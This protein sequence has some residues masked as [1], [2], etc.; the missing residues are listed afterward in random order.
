M[1]APSQCELDKCLGGHN[2]LTWRSG[3]PQNYSDYRV[4]IS[5]K[6]VLD[7][8]IKINPAGPGGTNKNKSSLSF[9]M[10]ILLRLSPFYYIICIYT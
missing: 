8:L 6:Q 10:F 5:F 3:G 9:F 7:G 4:V 2:W 1:S